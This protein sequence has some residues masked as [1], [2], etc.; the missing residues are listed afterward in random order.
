[1][2]TISE[3][4]VTA[5]GIDFGILEC[6]EGPLALCVHGFPDSPWTYRHLM[7]ALAK[8]GYRAVAPYLR[9]YAPTDVPNDGRYDMRTIGDDFN[10]LHK[11]L[12]IGRA[13]V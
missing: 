12:E 10:A 5:N 11:A 13:H 6:G 9:G 4:T 8:A 1:M 2:A 7:P 3:R